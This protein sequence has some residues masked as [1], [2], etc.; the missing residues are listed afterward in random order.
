MDAKDHDTH[1]PMI[2][3]MKEQLKN[4][5]IIPLEDMEQP[6][7]SQDSPKVAA[8]EI[9]ETI[10]KSS[11]DTTDVL[12]EPQ[13]VTQSEEEAEKVA[14]TVIVD[15]ANADDSHANVPVEDTSSETV[16]EE[17]ERLDTKK[18]VEIME[19]DGKL[20]EH[21]R[22]ITEKPKDVKP[23]EAYPENDI[24]LGNMFNFAKK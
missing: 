17:E 9:Q 1:N 3:A 4:T 8:K 20:E 5:R 6:T 16:T 11:S 14:E 21:T 13:K 10:P 7:E 22:Q 23:K 24:D 15:S 18:L 12:E 2:E 19:E